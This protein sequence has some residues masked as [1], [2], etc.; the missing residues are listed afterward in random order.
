[1]LAFEEGI[2]EKKV[3]IPSFSF[4]LRNVLE[5]EIGPYMVF[6]K[7]ILINDEGDLV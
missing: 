4:K 2:G 7:E 3:G 5:D 1:M 6:L